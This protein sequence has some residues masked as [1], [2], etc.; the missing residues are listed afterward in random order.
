MRCPYCEGLNADQAQFCRYCGR[1]FSLPT[2]SGQP[3]SRQPPPQRPPYQQPQ[4]PAY[5]PP[6]PPQQITPVQAP[7][8]QRPDPNPPAPPDPPEPQYA[9]SVR[10]RRQSGAA[11]APATLAPTAPPAPEP[12]APFPPRNMDQLRA[13]EPGALAYTLV[14]D[15][16]G[17]GSKKIVRITYPR[18]TAW[19]QVAT[20]L[21]AF[22]E[23]QTEQFNTIVIQGVLDQDG[24]IYTFNNG[25]LWFDRHVLLGSQLINRYQIET[26]TGLES[27]SVRIVLAEE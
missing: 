8:Y 6:R 26:G 4:R 24:S 17:M 19:Q 20:L 18:C 7:P 27:D 13:L 5:L 15:E 11:P 1:S 9:S 10:R 3:A 2:S 23:Y 12:P 16:V 22:K 25:Q 14:G 21:K